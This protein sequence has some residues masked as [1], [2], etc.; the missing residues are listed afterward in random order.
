MDWDSRLFLAIN[1]MA[2]RWE[3][4]DWLMFALSQESNLIVPVLLL[5]MYWLWRNGRE[6]I[7]GAPVLAGLIGISDWLGGQCKLLIARPRPCHVLHP[8][9]ELVG[10]GGT[11]S[12]PSNHAMNSA[13]AASFLF[14][15]YP[16]SGWV[17]WPLVGLIGLSRVYLGGHYVTD[18]LTGWALGGMLGVGLGAGL[19]TWSRFRPKTP[20]TGTMA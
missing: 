10:C 17:S 8:V 19:C 20:R 7:I 11:F 13:V 15:L 3:N 6:A 16:N 12:M 1:G 4:V 18:V 2:G 14:M 9:H 5:T